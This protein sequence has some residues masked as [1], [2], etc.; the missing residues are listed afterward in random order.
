MS[1]GP[2]RVEQAI[3]ATFKRFPDQTFSTTELGPIVYPGVNRLEKKHRVSIIRAAGKVA[4]RI[5]W[6]Y[7]RTAATAGEMVYYNLLNARSYRLGKLRTDFAENF[8]PTPLHELEERLDNPHAR[9][10]EWSKIQP[11]GVWAM[12]VE[13]HKADL[14][15]NLTEGERLRQELRR[16]VEGR[17]NELRA[18]VGR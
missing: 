10:S 13:I 5:A 8:R 12:H 14:K 16:D 3:E 2:G 15:G 7:R 17:M 6:M 4:R 1:R 9:N 11:G 18:K